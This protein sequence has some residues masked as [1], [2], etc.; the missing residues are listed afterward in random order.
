M[1]L[2]PVPSCP[3]HSLPQPILPGN[4]VFPFLGLVPKLVQA[5]VLFFSSQANCVGQLCHLE[6]GGV[7]KGKRGGLL[8]SV[9]PL[10][11]LGSGPLPLSSVAPLALLHSLPNTHPLSL[12][13]PL[14]LDSG[15]EHLE[16]SPLQL[17]CLPPSF[18]LSFFCKQN[19]NRNHRVRTGK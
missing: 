8:P 19:I 11:P 18:S 14:S 5:S 6:V 17:L 16:L 13:P 7:E 12:P 15:P 9:F 10:C 3:R 1:L 2:R 4:S